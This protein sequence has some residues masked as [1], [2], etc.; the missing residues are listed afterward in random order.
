MLVPKTSSPTEKRVL[1]TA[2]PICINLSLAFVATGDTHAH[3]YT[4]DLVARNERCRSTYILKQSFP[5][6]DVQIRYRTRLLFE[7]N[8]MQRNLYLYAHEYIAVTHRRRL[9]L[10]LSEHSGVMMT[11]KER[12]DTYLSGEHQVLVAAMLS[13]LHRAHGLWLHARPRG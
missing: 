4:R 3:N 1:G 11:V 2:G 9:K 7:D 10:A 6:S 8:I 5:Y 13:E 12:G